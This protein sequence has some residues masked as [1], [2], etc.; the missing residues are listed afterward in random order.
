MV[1]ASRCGP[2]GLQVGSEGRVGGNSGEFERGACAADRFCLDIDHGGVADLQQGPEEGRAG[3]GAKEVLHLPVG[4]RYTVGN[5]V[6]STFSDPKSLPD[7]PRGGACRAPVLGFSCVNLV[8]IATMTSAAKTGMTS[9]AAQWV[10]ARPRPM[11]GIERP[12]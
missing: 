2:P 4:V 12:T 7:Q 11:T 6:N 10:V 3:V 8:A 9:R 5:G 1:R